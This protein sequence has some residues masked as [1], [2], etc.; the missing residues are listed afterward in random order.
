MRYPKETWTAD[1]ARSHCDGRD[2]SFE[3]AGKEKDSTEFAWKTLKD[4]DP[5]VKKVLMLKKRYPDFI[6]NKEK[7]MQLLLSQ[8]A[9]QVTND[10]PIKITTLPLYLGKNGFETP[11]CC[12]GNDVDC[13]LCGSWGVFHTA[14][15]LG[16]E[17]A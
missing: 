11:F 10:C 17:T 14:F 4:R 12:Y 15:M 9:L 3:A 1:A 7:V 5:A 6:L 8:N 2:G 16:Y 13:D